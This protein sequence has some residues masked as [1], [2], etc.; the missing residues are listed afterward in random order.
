MPRRA[1]ISLILKVS[2]NVNA[3][4]GIGIRVPIKKIITWDRKVKAFVSARCIRRAIRKRLYEKGFKIDPLVVEEQLTDVGN[5]FEYI[6]DDLFGYLYPKETKPRIG[7]IKLSPLIS[8]RHTEV[9][10]EFA[11]RFPRSFVS[12]APEEYPVPF[13]VEVAEWVGKMNVIVSDRIGVIKKD[14]ELKK[15]VLDAYSKKKYSDIV[16]SDKDGFIYLKKDVRKKRLL[17]FLEVLLREGWEFP[18]GSQSPNVPEYYYAI[19]ATT[20][21]FAPISGFVDITDNNELD[22]SLIERAVSL[23][24]DVLDSLIVLYYR[25]NKYKWYQKAENKLLLSKEG[26]LSEKIVEILNSI[27]EYIVY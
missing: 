24:G 11:A 17:A 23:Y 9:K 4:I 12:G 14:R 7:P 26:N 13:E 20:D 16:E 25:E 10:V 8:L 6:D 5:P 15:S 21:R 18:R 2:G 19:I 3:D 1:F 22:E 27:V